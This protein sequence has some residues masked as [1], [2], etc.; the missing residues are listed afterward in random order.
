M[1]LNY[2]NENGNR[3]E[4]FKNKDINRAIKGECKIFIDGNEEYTEVFTENLLTNNVLYEMIAKQLTGQV[5][6]DSYNTYTK[7]KKDID[8]NYLNSGNCFNSIIL[9]YSDV[10]EDARHNNVIGTVTGFA[11]FDKSVD[12]TNNLEGYS[13][14][15]TDYRDGKITLEC[16]FDSNKINNNKINQVW[17]S[18]ASGIDEGKSKGGQM[19]NLIKQYNINPLSDVKSG[20]A[21]FAYNRLFIAEGDRCYVYNFDIN[22]DTK[23]LNLDLSL[24]CSLPVETHTFCYNKQH[25]LFYI[26]NDKTVFIMKFNKEFTILAQKTLDFSLNI[27]SF[28]ENLICCKTFIESYYDSVKTLM[29]YD[30]DFNLIQT[31]A[32]PDTFK[33]N[34]SNI[35]TNWSEDFILLFSQDFDSPSYMYILDKEFEVIS[36][37]LSEF[38]LNGFTKIQYNTKNMFYMD[39]QIYKATINHSTQTKLAKTV[40]KNLGQSMRISYS[41][42]FN[43]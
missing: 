33:G 6:I 12:T 5:N 28:G 1:A 41:F 2:V 32:L 14:F 11:D 31:K 4:L 22:Q 27:A 17:I 16:S 10:D 26:Q 30:K 43:E 40:E 18:L 34:T 8:L 21:V 29:I 39:K 15:T 38:Y 35:E 19:I 23:L 9:G 7:D 20:C 42:T 3:T 13:L 36:Y 25:D 37:V 24:E